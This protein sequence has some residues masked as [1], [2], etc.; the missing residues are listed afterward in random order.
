VKDPLFYS[1]GNR[2]TFN[3]LENSMALDQLTQKKKEPKLNSGFKLKGE[4][5]KLF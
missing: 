5:N 1:F 4:T 2:K 3:R